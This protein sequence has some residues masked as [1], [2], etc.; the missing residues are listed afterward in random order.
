[1]VPDNWD[2]RQI[3]LHFEGVKSASYVWVN[4]K[5]VGLQP[6]RFEPAEYDVT[7]FVRP[8]KNTIAVKVLRY[9]DGSF[10]ENQDMWRLSGIYR[11]VYL[12]AAPKVHMRDYFFFTDF[13]E[14]YENAAFN[15]EV[16]LANYTQKSEKISV[17]INLWDGDER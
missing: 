10:L 5:E 17:Q 15:F 16:E 12:F 14:N 1:V 2:G 6:G 7:S 4:G 8:G 13:D 11:N 3:F 9:S